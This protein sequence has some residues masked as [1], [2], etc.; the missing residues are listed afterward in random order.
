MLASEN[1]H[2]QVTELLLNKQADVNIATNKGFTALM[3]AS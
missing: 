3:L 2:F 1:G